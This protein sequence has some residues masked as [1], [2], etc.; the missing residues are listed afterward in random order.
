MY[1]FTNKQRW[2]LAGITVL[3]FPALLVNLGIVPLYVEEPRRATVAMEMIFRGNWLVPTINGAFYYLKPPFFNWILA[4]VYQL[5]GIHNEFITRLPTVISLLAFGLVIFLAGKKYISNSFGALSALLF[6]TA[7]GNLFF[8]GLLAEIDIFYSLVTYTSLICLFHFFQRKQYLLLFLSIYFLGAV[9]TLTKGLPSLVFTGLSLLAFFIVN[10]QFR[11]LF[12]LAHLA[13][14]VLFIALVSTYFAAYSRQGDVVQYLAN[15]TVESGKR[16]SGET[17]WDYLQ[18]MVLYPLDTLMNLLPA[19]LLIIFAFRRSFLKNIRGNAF[20]KFA[21][22][23]V[24]VHF[25]VYWLPPG[26]KQRYIL[27]LYP[28]IIQIFTYF[29]LSYFTKETGKFRVFSILI[30]A[31]LIIGAFVCLAPLF[32]S[33]VNIIRGLTVIC[34]AAFFLMAALVYFQLK[35]PSQTV[36]TMIL[37]MVLLRV[38]FGLTVLPVRA[39]EGA[40]PANKKAALDIAA[41]VM[42]EE[43]CIL[44]PSYVPMQTIYYFERERGEIL[45][46]CRQVEPGRFYIVEK[47]LLSDYSFRREINTLMMNP[48]K[49]ISD[50]F[51]IEDKGMLS[52]HKYETHLEFRLQK[53]DYLLLNL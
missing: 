20:M 28:F 30:T 3:L 40:A 9:G 29:Y 22:L 45:P 53:R 21:L 42:G 37:A 24:A 23:M 27:M 46:V 6:I 10:R 4:S 19:S 36:I 25:P 11:K 41:I 15:L 2:A 26:G 33:P 49:P 31:A 39:A 50:Q 13:G 47:I 34:V 48:L 17:F 12:S 52:G 7:S 1:T 18:H 8:N 5:T 43:A 14:I 38:F 16:F 32:G 44:A 51:S 35:N